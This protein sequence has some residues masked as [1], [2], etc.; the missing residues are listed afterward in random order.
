VQLWSVPEL[1]PLARLKGHTSTINGVAFSSDGA[2]LASMGRNSDIRLWDL[3]TGRLKL[4]FAENQSGNGLRHAAFSPGGRTLASGTSV[5]LALWNVAAGRVVLPLAGKQRYLS[6]PMFSPDG[7]TLVIGGG[8][9]LPTMRPV[10]LLQAPSLAEIEA[11]EK[12]NGQS[13]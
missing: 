4:L 2:L 1:K 10:E 8:Q 7:N 3:A 11:A 5:S 9:G 12:A 6:A 13:P